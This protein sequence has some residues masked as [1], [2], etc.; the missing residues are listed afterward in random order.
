MD[1]QKIKAIQ[2]KPT[3]ALRVATT[4]FLRNATRL[5]AGR[6]DMSEMA[7]TL[8]APNATHYAGVSVKQVQH[9][10]KSRLRLLL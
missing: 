7:F 6:R 4:R 3:M 8:A 1:Y 9:F 5:S 2:T 10:E